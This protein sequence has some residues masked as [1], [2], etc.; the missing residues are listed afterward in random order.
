MLMDKLPRYERGDIGSIPVRAANTLLAQ[1]IERDSSKVKVMGSS[2]LQRA[3]INNMSRY[4]SGLRGG[5]AT[6]VETKVCVGSNPTLLSIS[7][8][9]ASY[10]SGT[11]VLGTT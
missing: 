5:A 2:P 1:W 3:I 7:K 11:V 8:I 9:R 10:K 6:S 4:S